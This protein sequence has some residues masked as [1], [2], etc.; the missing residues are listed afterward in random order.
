MERLIL[1]NLAIAFANNQKVLYFDDERE[2]NHICR[3]VELGEEEMTISNVEY[4]YDVKFDDIKII[5]RPFSDLTKAFEKNMTKKT[6]RDHKRHK[7]NKKLSRK[8]NK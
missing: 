8:M 5:V 4:Q 1:K 2:L 3:I 7:E 6:K